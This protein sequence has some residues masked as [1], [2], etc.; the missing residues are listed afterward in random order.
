MR[1]ELLYSTEQAYIGDTT[2]YVELYDGA[3]LQMYG[4]GEGTVDWNGMRG[5]IEW[6]NFPPRRPDGVYLPDITGVIRFDGSDHPIMYR[7][8]G[9]SLL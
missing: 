2:Q 5:R 9:I 7:M 8:H 4:R 3:F 1:S 6:T